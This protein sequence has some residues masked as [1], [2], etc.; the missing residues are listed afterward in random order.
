MCILV[1]LLAGTGSGVVPPVPEESG[2]S[3]FANI[4]A[5]YL[6][7]KTNMISGNKI[8]TIGDDT[9]DSIS[10]SPDTEYKTIPILNGEV[11]Y[12]FGD[13]RTQIY[14]GNQ[15]EDVLQF[16]TAALL[17]VRKELGDKGTAAVSYVFSGLVT[18]VWED[19]Y[20]ANAERDETDRN[21]N[22]IR[23]E[24]DRLY[25]SDVGVQYQWRKIDI[26]DELSGTLGGLGLTP[27][28]ISL[29]DREGDHHRGD[30]Y[31]TWRLG[32][33][34]ALVPAFRY[35][36]SDL[37]GDAMASDV[38]AFRLN[39]AFR[40]EKYS[41]VVMGHIGREDFDERNPIYG[42]TRDDDVYGIGVTG[43]LHQPFGLPEGFSLAGTVGYY[44]AN[45][46]IDFYN[47]QA[48]MI[49]TSIF[50]SF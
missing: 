30:V 47:A 12:T 21:I 9:I 1:M 10:G 6:E 19:P 4:G 15:L 25:G 24:W 28:Q 40:S 18:E 36:K 16:D 49:G 33:G 39:Y 46:N 3:G 42:R 20:V 34:H 29:L 50:Y 23:L 38:Y 2:V 32:G 27:G 5:A 48:F 43:F 41:V 13:S 31:Y 8:V 26:D 35:G 11:A 45:S 22:G 14:V 7:V 17:G 44:E 37:D